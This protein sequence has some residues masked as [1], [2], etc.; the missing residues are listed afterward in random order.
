MVAIGAVHQQHIQGQ[1]CPIAYFSKALKPAKMRYSTF[2]RELLAIY[3]SLNHFKY[4]I[5]GCVFH[6]LTDQT[7]YIRYDCM[8]WQIHPTSDTST[9]CHFSVQFIYSTCEKRTQSCC[10]CIVMC[11]LWTC[12][13]DSQLSTHRDFTASA[14]AQTTDLVLSNCAQ[15]LLWVSKLPL[16]P[17]Q[18]PR[19]GVIRHWSTKTLC[20]TQISSYRL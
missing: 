20:S 13:F 16:W 3:L 7:P 9:G 18:M 1:W 19:F 5:E 8:S 10:W 15:I 11:N 2:D 14:A 17:C 6:V 12:N 4:F